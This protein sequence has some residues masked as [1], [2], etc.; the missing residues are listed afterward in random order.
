[1]LWRAAIEDL[2][3][4]FCPQLCSL[5][6]GVG[7]D[8]YV[9]SGYA[10]KWITQA[11]QSHLGAPGTTDG[12]T[13]EGGGAG[14]DDSGFGS[15]PKA[16]APIKRKNNYEIIV[17]APLESGYEAAQAEKVKLAEEEAA[18]EA[19]RVP[20]EPEPVDELNGMRVHFWVLLRV[21]KRMVTENLFCDAVT[22]R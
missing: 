2:S 22:G 3:C 8:A 18:A 10:P 20:P 19:A 11:S 14:I 9:V 7:Y 1:M 21:G 4:V 15:S 12:T 17:P 13:G 16:R 6:L 5:L